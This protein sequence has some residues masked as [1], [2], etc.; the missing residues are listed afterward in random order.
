MRKCKLLDEKCKILMADVSCTVCGII[1]L[2]YDFTGDNMVLEKTID[3]PT[4]GIW[5]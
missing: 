5:Q 4:V 3:Y 1:Y 2:I